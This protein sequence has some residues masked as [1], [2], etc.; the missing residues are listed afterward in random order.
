[1]TDAIADIKL[2]PGPSVEVPA[3]SERPTSVVMTLAFLP[4]IAVVLFTAGGWAALNFLGYSIMVFAAGYGIISVAL[5]APARSRTIF[6]APATGILAISGVTALWVRLG[7]PLIWALFVWLGLLVVGVVGLWRDHAG[8]AKSTVA[9]GLTLALFS[10]LICGVYFLPT[11]RT[12]MIL[13]RDGSFNWR[14]VDTQH[15]HAIAASIKYSGSP[16][17][18]PGTFTAELFYHFGPYAPAAAISKADGLDL[19]DAVAR[20]THGA[21][22]WTLVLSCFGLGMLLSRKAN[23]KTVGG[24]ISVAGLFFYGSLLTLFS[25]EWASSGHVARALLFN[26]PDVQVLA[27]GG[28]FD[29]LLVGHSLL[30]GLVAITAIMGLCLA[31]SGHE[32]ELTW[33]DGVLLVLPALAV[34]VNLLAAVYCLAA[35][36]IL[37]FWGRLR[38]IRSWLSISLMVGLF[39]VAWHITG[40]GQAPDVAHVTIKE[41]AASQ[42]WTL[43]VWVIIGLGFRIVGLR[44]ISRPLKDPLSVLVLISVLGWLAYAL[45][46]NLVHQNERYGIYFLQ[47]VLS[48]F[49]FSRVTPGWWHGVERSEMIGEW[50]RLAKKCM[51][52]VCAA[53][54]LIAGIAVATHH[55]TG[56]SHFG[57]KLLLSCLL[58][59][60]LA[61]MSALMRRNRR[62][63]IVGSA[64]VMGV[65]LVGFLAWVPNWIRYGVG[66][67]K[68]G[69][70]YPPG[71]VLG[72]L[73]L[74]QLMAPDERFATNKHAL[75]PES[76]A[77]PNERSYGYSALS[78]RPVLLEGY[79]S[80]GEN[81][82]PWFKTLLRDNDSLFSTTDP[83]TLRSIAES[84]HVRWLV[85]RPGTD[86]SLPRPLPEWLVEQQNCG[87]LKIYRIRQPGSQ[88]S[89]T[90]DKGGMSR[91]DR[92]FGSG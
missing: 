89:S 41:H 34:P 24:I 63:S 72:L 30:H 48:I 11:A 32:S 46:F 69:I 88:I 35:T 75:D 16:P 39:L 25:S 61:A 33:R 12:D 86:I 54:V 47:G 55:H 3:R 36:G 70:T 65:L 21:W 82:L 92:R 60:L 58:L 67:V 19:G 31:R 56:I 53:G 22:L 66:V 77:P 85:A 83:E 27:D 14:F 62:F 87:D 68:T 23:G 79:L 73:R 76:L 9:H 51:I 57:P 42:W 37:L 13:R 80:R 43:A 1:M 44:W 78:E 17:V 29:L 40:Y 10:A 7:L 5:P 74:R 15:F 28:P 90:Q 71:E 20:V 45:P 18:T 81:M 50:L 2:S 6:L 64:V 59:A 49:A 52:F 91:K 84:Y 4:W 38:A 26:I 8:W